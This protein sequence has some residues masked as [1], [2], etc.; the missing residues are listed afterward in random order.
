MFE[1]TRLAVA[2]LGGAGR[3]SHPRPLQEGLRRGTRT[4]RAAGEDASG[5]SLPISTRDDGKGASGWGHSLSEGVVGGKALEALVLPLS[6]FLR[7]APPLPSSCCPSRADGVGPG[8]GLQVVE[9]RPRE[10][11]TCHDRRGG[12]G[13][14]PPSQC[15]ATP[16]PEKSGGGGV[17]ALEEVGD[18]GLGALSDRWATQS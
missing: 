9:A 1:V 16:L 15:S 5:G 7:P 3:P 8:L 18:R 14:L 6:P 11:V 2:E 17:G 13:A 4:G 10:A 12:L